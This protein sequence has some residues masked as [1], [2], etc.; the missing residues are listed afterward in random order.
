MN[1]LNN[2]QNSTP[3]LQIIILPSPKK[4]KKII[5]N[6]N[7]TFGK[8]KSNINLKQIKTIIDLNIDLI[9]VVNPNSPLINNK[10]SLDLNKIHQK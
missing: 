1:D 8:S 10:T 3:E 6:T 7:M 9:K 5:K 4:S 2:S